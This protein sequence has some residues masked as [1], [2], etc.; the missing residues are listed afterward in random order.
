MI[1]LAFTLIPAAIPTAEPRAHAAAQPEAEEGFLGK[2]VLWARI[3]VRYER[4]LRALHRL[5]ERDLD[6]LGIA[7][8][9]F[10]QLA[11]RHA[12]GAAPLGW[13]RPA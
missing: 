5:D 2:L 7:R 11:W 3:R 10:P 8:V 1:N 6:D 9:D 12:T 4:A 13:P